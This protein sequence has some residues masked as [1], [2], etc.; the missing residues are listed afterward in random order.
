[1]LS[2]EILK[3]V[4][5]E[6]WIEYDG[7]R[8]YLKWGHYLDTDDKLDPKTIKRAFVIGPDGIERPV[9]V[10]R[11]KGSK[12]GLFLE[13]NTENEGV[14]TVVVEYDKGVYTVTADNKWIFAEKI[15]AAR[16]GYEVKESRWICGFVKTYVV[17]GNTVIR[18]EPRLELELVPEV[19]RNFNAGDR[20]KVGLFFRG[21]PTGG[22]I[23]QITGEGVREYE[24]ASGFAEIELVNGVNVVAARYVDEVAKIAGVCDKRN[25]TATLTFIVEE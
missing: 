22:I 19:V 8:A 9:A 13:F 18:P 2:E 5:H 20:V 12:D 3:L 17:V 4:N 25:M 11:D 16:L 21:K 1:M 6:P 14:Y 10:G 15:F 23:K 24:T 7:K